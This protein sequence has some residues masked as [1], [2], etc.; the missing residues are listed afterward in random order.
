MRGAWWCV[1]NYPEVVCGGCVAVN[2]PEVEREVS[3]GQV[4]VVRV[5][6]VAVREV[7]RGRKSW[8]V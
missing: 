6:R 1:V 2:Y 8:R 4:A 5:Q 3:G 7:P